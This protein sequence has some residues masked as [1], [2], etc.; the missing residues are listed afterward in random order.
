MTEEVLFQQAESR[1]RMDVH[2]FVCYAAD[3]FS[4]L[5]VVN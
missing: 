1:E 4:F 2:G 5:E 3:A